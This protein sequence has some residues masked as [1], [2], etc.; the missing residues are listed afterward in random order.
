MLAGIRRIL[1]ITTPEDAP[2]FRRLL[3][4]G[5][6]WGLD[7][8][9]ATQPRPEGLAQAFVIGADFIRNQ[10]C[11]MVLG[12]NLFFGHG[13]PSQLSAAARQT[14]GATVFA[15]QV[16]NPQD[17]GVVECDPAGKALT[18]E[19]KPKQPR[20]SWAVTGLYFY[21]STVVSKAQSLKPSARGELEITDLNRLYLE[22]GSLRVERLGR[23]TAWLDT[24]T[25]ASLMQAGLFI[26]AI[27]DRQGL[28]IGCPEEVA[29]R[30]GFID[31]DQLL[32]LAE[33][34]GGSDYAAYL[35]DTA[36]L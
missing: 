20:S 7:L 16:S 3:S 21:D 28:K 17:Y 5:H 32:R 1:I 10:P 2:A 34:F 4:D 23:G 33:G 18:I 6:Q 26:Q 22:E 19:E 15:Y 12:D 11:S 27:E 9:Y 29:Y 35:R 24:G 8:H 13:L 36:S 14:S 31:R 25:H 30:M